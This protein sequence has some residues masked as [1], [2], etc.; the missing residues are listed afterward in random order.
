MLS[1]TYPLI[2][3]AILV[4]LRDSLLFDSAPH[5]LALRLRHMWFAHALD[6]SHVARM[7]VHPGTPSAH[8]SKQS[9]RPKMTYTAN[10][11]C[12]IGQWDHRPREL[13]NHISELPKYV[14]TYQIFISLTEYIS[15]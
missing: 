4:K 1:K 12:Y 6:S 7:S 15:K 13:S 5:S 14:F 10:R 8:A 11:K 9:A 2:F 3:A